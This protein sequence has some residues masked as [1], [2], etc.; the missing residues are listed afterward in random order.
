MIGLGTNPPSIISCDIF[1]TVL[2][3]NAISETNRIALMARRSAD[4]LAGECGIAVNI[5]A[6]R[7]ARLD[8]QRYA[9]RAIDLLHPTGEVK[10]SK[11]METMAASLGLGHAAAELLGRAEMATEATQLCANRSLLTWLTKRAGEGIR[12]IAI[13]DTWHDAAA[14]GQLLHAVAPGHPIAKIYTSADLGATKRSGSIFPTI[15]AAEAVAAGAILHIGDD[16][17][18]DVAMPRRAGLRA[19]RIDRPRLAIFGRRIDGAWARLRNR[20]PFQ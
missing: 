15:A 13:S 7:R 16:R 19:Y 17:T 2:R 18:A 1:D 20:V 6:L 11:M 14:I 12:I 5:D 4:M 3:R 9:Y 8:V 10:F